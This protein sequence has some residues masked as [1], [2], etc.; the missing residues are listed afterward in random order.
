MNLSNSV[1]TSYKDLV[2][3]VLSAARFDRS[4]AGVGR[5][6]VNFDKRIKM[7]ADYVKVPCG[8]V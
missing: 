8:D 3:V 1:N 7:D 5:S 2:K 4:L 6:E